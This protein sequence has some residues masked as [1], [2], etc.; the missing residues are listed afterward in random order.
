[1]TRSQSA[2]AGTWPATPLLLPLVLQPLQCQLG[3]SGPATAS[4]RLRSA[5]PP[6]HR[7]LLAGRVTKNAAGDAALQL[8]QRPSGHGRP[9]GGRVAA[10]PAEAAAAAP[11]G[12]A[13]EAAAPAVAAASGAGAGPSHGV[14]AALQ[15]AWPG[16]EA[17]VAQIKLR[18]WL[19]C[20]VCLRAPAM[21]CRL[22]HCPNWQHLCLLQAAPLR[23]QQEPTAGPPGKRLTRSVPQSR[24][25]GSNCAVQGRVAV[26]PAPRP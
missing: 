8:L 14:T 17:C 13:A 10:P 25:A 20:L 24:P 5:S 21:S 4:R 1:M 18:S 7:R 6:P 15:G 2:A 22:V 9:A 11:A 16:A 23:R 12:A 3:R 19:Q 26:L